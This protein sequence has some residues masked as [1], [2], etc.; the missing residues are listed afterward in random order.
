MVKPSFPSSLLPK[1][2]WMTLLSDHIF[3]ER[4][5]KEGRLMEEGH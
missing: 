4:N 2:E 5:N 1:K 3:Y